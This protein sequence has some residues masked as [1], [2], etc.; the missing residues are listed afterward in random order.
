VWLK[1]DYD[2]VKYK[3]VNRDDLKR[4]LNGEPSELR[5]RFDCHLEIGRQFRH[6]LFLDTHDQKSGQSSPINQSL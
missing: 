4:Y 5:R 3:L 1:Y 6:P 2:K